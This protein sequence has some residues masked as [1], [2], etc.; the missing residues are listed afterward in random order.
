MTNDLKSIAAGPLLPLAGLAMAL[1]SHAVADA[2]PPRQFILVNRTTAPIAPGD[3]EEV[4]RALPDVPG[5]NI[6]IGIGYIFSYFQSSSNQTVAALRQALQA[7][8]ETGTPVLIQL[9]GEN[10][11]DG[12]PDLWN[13]WDASLPGFD[14]ANRE[15]VEWFSWSSGQAL[16]LAWRN[17]GRQLRVRPPPNLMSARYRR[18]CHE[19]MAQLIPVAL[20][21]WRALPAEKQ[22]LFVGIKLGHES[23]IGV[24]AWYYPNGN[25]LLHRPAHDDPAVGLRP[26]EIPSRGVA[27]IGYAA[28]KTAGIRDQGEL[29]EA[30]LAEIVKRHL[31]DLCLEAARL[32][33]PR[34][35]LF[36]HVAGWKEGESLYGSGVNPHSCPGWSFYKHAADPRQDSGVQAALKRSDAPW[37]AAT[38]WLY[39]GPRET[40]PW[41]Q[42]LENTLADR[43]CRYVCIYNWEGIRDNAPVLDAIRQMVM[44]SVAEARAAIGEV[45]H[46]IVSDVNDGKMNATVEMPSRKRPKSVIPR[47]RHPKTSPIKSAKVNGKNGTGFNKGKEAITLQGLTGT[48]A[49][50]ANY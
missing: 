12:R 20:E 11:W 17:W 32:G 9:D 40:K 13:W 35:K 31:D 27:T 36:T 22:E 6:R 5:A 33:V 3:F 50:Q 21:W 4:K 30:D 49:V 43:R 15:N 42:A 16:K 14:P 1:A 47:F 34:G 41:R 39:Q 46:A 7:A 38:E 25:D 24:N 23:S 44:A 45:A 18:A 19:Q 37:W 26:D 28:V 10:W 8:E 48:V 2:E 29:T